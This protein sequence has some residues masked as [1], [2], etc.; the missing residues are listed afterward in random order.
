MR[1]ARRIPVLAQ[2]PIRGVAIRAFLL[3]SVVAAE[4]APRPQAALAAQQPIPL[5][6][7]VVTA[8]RRATPAWTV[9]SHATVIEGEDLERAGVVYVA[10]ALRQ[11]GGLA[12]TRAGSFGAVTSAFL[13]GA[14]SD[15]VQVLVD[16]VRMNEP[17]GRFD[18]GAMTVDN[19]ERIEI[20]RGPG[21][22]LY[23]SDAVAGIVHILTR[24]GR[25]APSADVSFRAGSFGSRRWTGGTSGATGPVSYAFSL[26]RSGTDGVLPYN[27]AHRTTT[28]SGRVHLLPASRTEVVLSVRHDARRFHYPTDGSG[29]LVDRNAYTFG[30]ATAATLD[31]GRRWGDAWETRLALAL[32]DWDSGNDD[33]PDGPADTLGFF[34]SESLADGRR[35]TADARAVW[36]PA[37]GTA[38]AVGAELEQ[39]AVRSLSRSLSQYGPSGQ[40]TENER[41]NRA[42]YVQANGA[43]GGLALDG[44]ARLE[45]N[46]RYGTA[47]T[48]RTGAVLRL[49]RTG[50]R[51][52]AAAGAGVKEPAF[53]ETFGSA[54]ATGNP[55][56]RPERSTSVEAGVDQEAGDWGSASLTAFFQ[57]FRDLIQYTFSPPAEGGA[58]FHNVARARSRGLEA[59]AAA[60]FGGVR[61]SASYA[62][63]DTEVQD[64]GFHEGPGAVFVDGQPL[65]RRPEHSFSASAAISA[66]PRAAVDLAFRWVGEREDR[67]FSTW[68]ATPV[69]LPAYSAIDLAVKV[70][71]AGTDG[72]RAAYL[73]IRAEN[74]L[75]RQYEEV[76]GF[77]APGRGVYV[78]GSVALGGGGPG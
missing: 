65:I 36:R 34:G 4:L 24:R 52:R 35:A 76:R 33:A 6:G 37:D 66:G 1:H 42:A 50:T 13:R 62:W 2:A 53:A 44:S 17:G 71:L 11:A 32:H 45:D 63:L 7:V 14:E 43:F 61:T 25:G 68:P 18:F 70:R 54:F 64:A 12:I 23:G 56:L 77:P 40:K 72:A 55:G 58:N 26:G 3:A 39:Q 51:L 5:E 48:W 22:A 73:T 60:R 49:A 30:D 74:L 10:D 59:E 78:G 31:A 75:D 8:H 47:A 15:H 28:A 19:V 27:N 21:S 69:V 16:G 20:V 57:N 29:A 46:E 41:W 38:L 9:A 67:D